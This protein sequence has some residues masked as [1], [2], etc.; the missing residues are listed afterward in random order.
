V[1][2][3]SNRDEFTLF[4]AMRYLQGDRY[5]AEQYPKLL[6][7]T[8]GPDAAAVGA[9]YPLDRYDSTASAYAAAVTDGEFA[10]VTERMA[11]DLAGDQPVYAYE[12]ND[13]QAPGP[14]PLRTVPF[15]VGASHSLE[16]RYLFD[17]GGTAALSPE[18]QT[19]SDQMIDYWS[20]FVADG[21]PAAQ[22]APRWPQYGQGSVLSLHP[23]GNR[24]TTDFGAD[25]Q[26]PFWAGLKS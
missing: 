10:C 22:A 23:D 17:V 6:A 5:T 3:G 26:C 7:D 13:R 12:F 11:A 18:Q 2:I 9:R 16:L 8:F 14:P 15:P 21:E 1:L 25:H 4:V 19:L 20:A 24:V